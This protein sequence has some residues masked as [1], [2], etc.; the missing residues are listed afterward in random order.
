LKDLKSFEDSVTAL[1]ADMMETNMKGAA[2][3]TGMDLDE[4]QAA[5]HSTTASCGWSCWR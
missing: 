3:G 4:A 2:A 5:G 1:A